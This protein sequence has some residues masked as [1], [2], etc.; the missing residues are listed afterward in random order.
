MNSLTILTTWFDIH[1]LVAFLVIVVHDEHQ[2]ET[3]VFATLKLLFF[4]E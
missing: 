2:V 3:G 4:K 1:E